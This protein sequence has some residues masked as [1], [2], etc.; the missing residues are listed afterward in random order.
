[1]AEILFFVL[2]DIFYA[3]NLKTLKPSDNKKVV[4]FIIEHQKGTN[5]QL[6]EIMDL[7]ELSQIF[8]VL[9]DKTINE[10]G[11]RSVTN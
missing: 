10:K 4:W 11:E 3:K 1:M 9:S 7:Y 5:L 6:Y 2:K 8:D